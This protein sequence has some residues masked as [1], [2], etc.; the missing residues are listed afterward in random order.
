MAV[1][2][3]TG[4]DVHVRSFPPVHA[5]WD[6]R[7][8][9]GTVPAL[10]TGLLAMWF[11]IGLSERLGWRALLLTTYAAGVVWMFSLALVDGEKGIGRILDTD[12]E[13][14]RTARS[15][16]DFPGALRVW[17]SRIPTDGLPDYIEGGNWPVHVAGHPPGA[18]GLFVLLYF[19]FAKF[20]PMISIWEYEEGLQVAAKHAGELPEPTFIGQTVAGDIHPGH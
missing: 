16:D 17:V 14:L 6:P 9:P 20:S 10:L 2:A 5:I 4:W 19:L 11:S 1:P 15:I 7:L 13:Y 3:V 18:L 12:Y 8:G